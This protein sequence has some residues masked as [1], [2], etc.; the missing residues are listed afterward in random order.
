M[1]IIIRH[2]L[3]TEYK[4]VEN[5]TREAFWNL[6]VPGCSEHYLVHKMREHNDFLSILDYVAIIDKKIVGNIMYVKSAILNELNEKIDTIS[7]GPVSVLPEY[8]RKCIGS[9]LLQHS[10]REAKD[11]EYKAVIIEGYPK[12]YCKYGFKSSKDYTISNIAGKYPY[13][14]LVLPLVDGI[15]EGHTWKYVESEV[16][17]CDENEVEKFDKQFVEKTKEYKYAQEE[18]L[19][20]VRAYVE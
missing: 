11:K 6:Y 2:E 20:S 9:A 16:Y 7:F 17:N 4:E 10:I 13:N 3:P 14:L 5:V 18:F 19:I 15:F 1:R 8:Q 12:N